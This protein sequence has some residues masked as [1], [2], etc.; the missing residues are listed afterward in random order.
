MCHEQGGPAYRIPHINIDVDG[1]RPHVGQ[2][3]SLPACSLS[4]RALASSCFSKIKVEQKALLPMGMPKMTISVLGCVDFHFWRKR[5][6]IMFA[7]YL[8]FMKVYNE[9]IRK[10]NLLHDG[11]SLK[12]SR[13]GTSQHIHHQPGTRH[14]WT[15]LH[16]QTN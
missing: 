15:N 2:L 4:R 11:E 7:K 6:D 10:T 13:P 8:T 12:N 16:T 1:K 9:T 14:G 5:A 3:H